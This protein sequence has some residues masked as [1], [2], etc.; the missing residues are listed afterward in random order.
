MIYTL[1]VAALMLLSGGRAERVD[2]CPDNTRGVSYWYDQDVSPTLQTAKTPQT[3]SDESQEDAVHVL[4]HLCGLTMLLMPEADEDEAAYL[5]RV[6]GTLVISILA[7]VAYAIL[8]EIVFSVIVAILTIV[9]VIAFITS[10]N[11]MRDMSRGYASY[12][13][14]HEFARHFKD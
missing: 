10:D 7:V 11:K 1:F 4:W 2:R 5:F 12:Y 3:Q 13:V 8:P 14:V 6:I 9:G